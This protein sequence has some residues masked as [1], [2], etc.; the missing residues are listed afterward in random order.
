MGFYQTSDKVTTST[1]K[2]CTDSCNRDDCELSCRYKGGTLMGTSDYY[3]KSGTLH[4]RDFNTR[5]TY[6]CC[7][8]CWKHWMVH[9]NGDDILQ[10][11]EVKEE[12]GYDRKL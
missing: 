9:Q 12:Q 6:V 11:E 2:A 7:R 3:D 5:Q 1:V 10:V 4:H 8:K